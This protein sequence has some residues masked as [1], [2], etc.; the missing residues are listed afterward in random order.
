M[1]KKI[2]CLLLI[3]GLLSSLGGCWSRK[4]LGDLAIVLAAGVDSAPGGQILLTVQIARPSA[5]GGGDTGQRATGAQQN[6]VWVISQ[7]GDTVYDAQRYLEAKV[8]RELYWGHTVILVLGEQM[9]RDGIRKV[10]NFFSRSPDTRE[11][12]WVLVS[13]G[14]AK[15]VLNSHS[16]L[17]TTSAQGVGA[18]VRSGV[19]VPVMLKDLSM[20]LASKG[21]NPVLPRIELTTSGSPQ[22]PGMAENIP[23]AQHDQAHG[24]QTHAEITITGTGVFNDDRL[25]GWLD[26]MESRGMLWLRD[27]MEEG[28]I[29]VPSPTEPGKHFSVRIDRGT[30]EVEPYYDGQNIWFDVKMRMDGELWEQQSMEKITEPQIFAA[31]EKSLARRIEQ[32]SRDVLEKARQVYGVDIFGFGDAWHRKY[33][34]EWP[35]LKDRWDEEFTAADV[36]ISVEAHIRR[37]GLTTNRVSQE[38]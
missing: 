24:T 23:R 21:T 4:E 32:K 27:E 7:T 8:S 25:V 22:G 2:L 36:H 3:L 30:T 5:F 17:E 38:E 33:P 15:E 16:Q 1:I 19:G 14:A 20:M 12:I 10:L 29:T 28:E 6:N 13:R 9:A 34:N 37:T 31:L 26:M 11:T 35:A 18:M